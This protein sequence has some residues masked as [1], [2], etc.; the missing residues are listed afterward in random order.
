MFL[1]WSG[2]NTNKYTLS[3]SFT[4]D[5]GFLRPG[6]LTVAAGPWKC[7][8]W[9][10]MNLKMQEFDNSIL[11]SFKIKMFNCHKV[12][13]CETLPWSGLSPI[14]QLHF[15]HFLTFSYIR[16]FLFQTTTH[17]NCFDGRMYPHVRERTVVQLR[18]KTETWGNA[19]AAESARTRRTSR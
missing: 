15:S 16:L 1:F 10:Y 9:K 14:V 4:G 18:E 5:S 8:N 17:W 12:G 13:F 2:S 6:I 19:A 11:S 7:K 3:N